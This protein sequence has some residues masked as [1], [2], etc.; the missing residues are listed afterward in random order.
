MKVAIAAN[1]ESLRD[2][3]APHFGQAKNYIVYDTKTKTFDVYL[4][5]EVSG[6]K[7]LPP[8]FLYQKGANVVITFSLG[9]K[10]FEKFKEYK[11]KMYKATENTVLENIKALKRDKIHELSGED[12]Y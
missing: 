3:V 11:I 12:I 7:E 9:F 5:P 2:Q 4:N 1:K 10:A 6:G 8:D